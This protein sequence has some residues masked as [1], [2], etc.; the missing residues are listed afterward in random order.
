MPTFG[1]LMACNGGW[2]V[3]L[4]SPPLIRDMPIPGKS[5]SGEPRDLTLELADLHL[6]LARQRETV[7]G[8]LPVPGF[9]A[10]STTTGEAEFTLEGLPIPADTIRSAHHIG[11]LLLEPMQPL[12]PI[13][14][15]VNQKF[16]GEMAGGMP[17]PE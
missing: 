3:V 6:G 17:V 12:R 2:T 16:S 15:R 5:R 1:D 8:G 11:G 4:E 7:V 10:S 14:V 13:T 9:A